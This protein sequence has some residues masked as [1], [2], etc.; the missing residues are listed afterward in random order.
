MHNFKPD[1]GCRIPLFFSQ[2]NRVGMGEII[3]RVYRGRKSFFVVK[4]DSGF[5]VEIEEATL[6]NKL[7]YPPP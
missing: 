5:D 4:T 1:V 3:D 6:E 2:S 7:I